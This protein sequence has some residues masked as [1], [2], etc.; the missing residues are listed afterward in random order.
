MPLNATFWF[1]KR[2]GLHAVLERWE[3][4]HAFFAFQKGARL[5][6]VMDV[7]VVEENEPQ[8]HNGT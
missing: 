5:D 7:I 3:T 1:L 6:Q 2:S 8:A 4:L